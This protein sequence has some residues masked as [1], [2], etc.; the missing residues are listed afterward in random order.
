MIETERLILRPIHRDD[1]DHVL[2]IFAD[3]RVMAAFDEAPF[4]R[5]QMA[6]WMQDHL[7]HEREHGY[8][9]L[10]VI[11]KANGDLIGDCALEQMEVEGGSC[12]ELGYDFRSDYWHQGLATEAPRAVLDYAVGTLG[13]S[14][15]ISLIRVGNDASR[16]VAERI[17]MVLSGEIERH[18]RRYWLYAL[19]AEPGK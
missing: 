4:D 16:R 2:S 10:A 3:P 9:A 5:S 19:P 14:R 12:V 11:L 7:D 13:L 17:G 18:G 6:A 15:L 8:G 1:L